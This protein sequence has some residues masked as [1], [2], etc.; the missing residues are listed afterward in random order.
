[1]EVASPLAY[2]SPAP[3][4]KRGMSCSPNMMDAS[5]RNLAENMDVSDDV[6]RVKRR[7]FVGDFSVDSLSERLSSHSPF[8]SNGLA[9]NMGIFGNN[10]VSIVKR[11]RSSTSSPVQ[12]DLTRVV[13]EQAAL[14][15]SLK[16]EKAETVASLAS[17]KSDHERTSKENIVL[18]K[19]VT[20]QQERL[21][22]AEGQVKVAQDYRVEAEDR[23]KKLEQ[24]VLSLRYHLQTQQSHVGNDF[25]NYPRPPDV[26]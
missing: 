22:N 15:E 24:V 20:I 25:M 10:N 8:F 14:I 19:A 7:R 1:M 11:N 4:T 3:G 18:R 21:N 23:I 2:T 17:L 16:K 5:G 12:N 6:H 9:G 13:E 26:Y